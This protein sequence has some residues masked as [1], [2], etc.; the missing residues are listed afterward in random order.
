MP[1]SN[2]Y[3]QSVTVYNVK[4][5]NLTALARTLGYNALISYN[6]INSRYNGSCEEFCRRRLK[7]T[8]PAALQKR[9]EELKK[10]PIC[11]PLRADNGNPLGSPRQASSDV[12]G[13]LACAW[14]LLPDEDRSKILD[15]LAPAFATTPAKLA[16]KIEGFISGNK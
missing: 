7:L 5:D 9:L 6:L 8:D 15:M 4:F 10:H 11:A 14:R 1:R 2:K 16:K 13:V 12:L 3:G